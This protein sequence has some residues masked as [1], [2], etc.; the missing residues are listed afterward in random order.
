MLIRVWARCSN[1]SNSSA[2][3][4]TFGG[5]EGTAGTTSTASF[6]NLYQGKSYQRIMYILW[7]LTFI[8]KYCSKSFTSSRHTLRRLFITVHVSSR[9]FSAMSLSGWEL[10]ENTAL[11]TRVSIVLVKCG[12]TFTI[13][14][15]WLLLNSC[16]HQRQEIYSCIIKKNEKILTLQKRTAPSS[17]EV[18]PTVEIKAYCVE[19][20]QLLWIEKLHH[21]SC[22]VLSWKWGSKVCDVR[23]TQ[24]GQGY[25][26]CDLETTNIGQ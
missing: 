9:I 5:R 2:V 13:H 16:L 6:C 18:W 11:W 26:K 25:V 1:V 8:S 21:P 4:A 12:F 3:A 23:N 10:G 24:G 7:A 19:A 15:P 14:S 17:S 20:H 22:R